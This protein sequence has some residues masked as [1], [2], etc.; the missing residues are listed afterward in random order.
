MGTLDDVACFDFG[1]VGVGF[2]DGGEYPCVRGEGAPVPGLGGG[3]DLA[4]CLQG[5]GQHRLQVDQ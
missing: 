4:L 2:A 3:V 5:D 1:L